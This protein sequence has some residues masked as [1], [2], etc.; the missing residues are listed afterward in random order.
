VLRVAIVRG[1]ALEEPLRTLL[2]SC[3]LPALAFDADGAFAA[4][5]PA[6][7]R[8]LGWDAETWRDRRIRTLGP[9]ESMNIALAVILEG[10]VEVGEA[11]VAAG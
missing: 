10:Q 7:G 5:N 1:G 11:T 9:G 6:S 2:D 8:M 3:D 4:A